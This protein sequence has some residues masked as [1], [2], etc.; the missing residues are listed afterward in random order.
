[1]VNWNLINSRTIRK[2][3]VTY[4]T[5]NY[6]SVVVDSIEKKEDA[7]RI[8]LM[9]DFYLMFN[10]KGDFVEMEKGRPN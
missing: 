7:Y 5:R 1:M 2:D 10:K 3:I 8:N 9:N 4:I 6:P